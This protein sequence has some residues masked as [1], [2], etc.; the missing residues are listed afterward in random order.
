MISDIGSDGHTGAPLICNT[1]RP[2]HYGM[3]HSGGDWISP[4]NITLLRFNV[5]YYDL[6]VGRNRGPMVVRLWR[7][8]YTS[9]PTEGI[10]RCEVVDASETLQTVYAGLYY[11]D[12][13][14]KTF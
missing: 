4:T 5:N 1:N 10:Y 8:P 14:G 2:P 12:T 11:S 3:P 13:G 9:H 7:L 6:G